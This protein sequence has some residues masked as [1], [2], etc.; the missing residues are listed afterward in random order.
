[1]NLIKSK[2][3][4]ELVNE[5]LLIG[6]SIGLIAIFHVIGLDKFYSFRMLSGCIAFI[7]ILHTIIITIRIMIMNYRKSSKWTK[8]IR[9]ENILLSFQI[10][11][12]LIYL[13]I[14]CD[15][16]NKDGPKLRLCGAIISIMYLFQ[17]SRR[18]MYYSLEEDGKFRIIF[19]I[20]IVLLIF[21]LYNIASTLGYEFSERKVQNIYLIMGMVFAIGSLMGDDIP[22][23]TQERTK[24]IPAIL[25]ISTTFIA[26]I[27]FEKFE[28]KKL[29]NRQ[30]SY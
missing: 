29:I 20:I 9:F 8:M 1:M 5:N 10:P 16:C 7:N 2:G 26:I 18:L 28:S 12:V 3:N 15:Y 22:Y 19:P 4:E 23:R 17:V 11:L 27:G 30:Y 24:V 6:L 25:T 14:I 21:L 13:L